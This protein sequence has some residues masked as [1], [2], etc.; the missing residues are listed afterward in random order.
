MTTAPINDPKQALDHLVKLLPGSAA[1]ALLE[2]VERG[3][4]GIGGKVDL[5]KTAIVEDLDL[6]RPDKLR[7]A[8]TTWL[9]PFLVDTEWL[10]RAPAPIPGLITRVDAGAIWH[11][12]LIMCIQ[13]TPHLITNL[14]GA[15]AIGTGTNQD[16]V[17]AA[18]QFVAAQ[19]ADSMSAPDT[20]AAWHETFNSARANFAAQA[21]LA[22]PLHPI[23]ESWFF[24][25]S[26]ILLAGQALS[27][28]L[29]DLRAA[30]GSRRP[31]D[32]ATASADMSIMM[33]MRRRLEIELTQADLDPI[34][35]YQVPSVFLNISR[36]YEAIG[37]YIQ[38]R[39]GMPDALVARASLLGHVRAL[40]AH[41]RTALSEGK[42][43]AALSAI[44]RDLGGALSAYCS[45][46][47]N[48]S[49]PD[50]AA[51][52]AQVAMLAVGAGGLAR[53]D[54]KNEFGLVQA[55]EQVLAAG[56]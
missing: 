15:S 52:H 47:A 13:S 34:H 44:G 10:A 26:A 16:V 32:S 38:N 24:W 23:D 25:I 22:T 36:H 5:L 27:E 30:I 45:D 43:G 55:A 14:P 1:Q 33:A 17:S 20:R 29:S 40:M 2:Q 53:L 39:L 35:A 49:A 48:V 7:R 51:I 54:S 41:L 37:A 6:R 18:A 8:F 46:I 42:S 28:P 56:G 4:M 50:R 21:E 12:S 9:Q 11:T 19:I 3:H 31:N